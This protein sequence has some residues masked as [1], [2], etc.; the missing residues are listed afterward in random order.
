ML[1]LRR[2]TFVPFILLRKEI[3]EQLNFYSDYSSA[4][5]N[6]QEISLDDVIP[7][8]PFV[9]RH[10][11]IREKDPLSRTII[12]S[13]SCFRFLLFYRTIAPSYYNRHGESLLYMALTKQR[14]RIAGI[15]IRTSTLDD[16]ASPLVVDQRQGWTISPR[17]C[18]IGSFCPRT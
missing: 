8:N 7:N 18:I 4:Y 13:P 5:Q 10:C 16:L 15:L 1:L 14:K 9:F 11:Q 2:K 17:Y 6:C 3:L 12:D